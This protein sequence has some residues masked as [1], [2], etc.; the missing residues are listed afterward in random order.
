MKIADKNSWEYILAILYT[1]DEELG[2]ITYGDI[3]AEAERTADF[4]HCFTEGDI[5]SLDDPER[6]WWR[7]HPSR[8]DSLDHRVMALM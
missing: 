5:T 7:R 8:E 2:R 1:T 4:R 3:Y 6:S